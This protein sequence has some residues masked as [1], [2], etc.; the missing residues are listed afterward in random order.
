MVLTL[1]ATAFAVDFDITVTPPSGPAFDVRLTQL[2][3]GPVPGGLLVPWFD[4]K[5][6]RLLFEV[7]KKKGEWRLGVEIS[8]LRVLED[9]T[10]NPVVAKTDTLKLNEEKRTRLLLSRPLSDEGKVEEWV[11]D[12]NVTP[13]SDKSD[14]A[15]KPSGAP[16]ED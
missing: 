4:G 16:T 14:K 12:A 13:G 9:G 3:P 6:A 1:V 5:Q 7:Y 10:W 15:A 8:E 11:L 2:E